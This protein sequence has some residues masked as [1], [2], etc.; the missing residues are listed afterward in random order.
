MEPHRVT[1][2]AHR[3]RDPPGRFAVEEVRVVRDVVWH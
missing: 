1:G 3:H 2:A